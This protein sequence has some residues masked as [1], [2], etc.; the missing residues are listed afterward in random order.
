[1]IRVQI[2]I[3]TLRIMSK[4]IYGS[5]LYGRVPGHNWNYS[6]CHSKGSIT[7]PYNKTENLFSRYPS[8]RQKLAINCGRTAEKL[9]DGQLTEY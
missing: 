8:L 3:S 7:F 1:M 2:I 9:P 4:Y 5:S 6:I